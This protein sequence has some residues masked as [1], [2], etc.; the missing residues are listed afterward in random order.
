[1]VAV[2]LKPRMTKLRNKEEQ[3]VAELPPPTGEHRTF[4]TKPDGLSVCYFT[5]ERTREALSWPGS[6]GG[7]YANSAVTPS[8]N[9]P[10]KLLLEAIFSVP[11][12]EMRMWTV[13]YPMRRNRVTGLVDN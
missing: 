5:I 3:R 13:G 9:P 2:R 6:Y 12:Q 4:T 8:A 7:A 11:F 10:Y 1:V